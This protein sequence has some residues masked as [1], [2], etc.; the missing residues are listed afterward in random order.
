MCLSGVEG[1]PL[2]C[3]IGVCVCVCLCCGHMAKSVGRGL[4]WSRSAGAVVVFVD[5]EVR[6]VCVCDIRWA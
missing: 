5:Q 4:R 2:D 3:G 1:R 6:C